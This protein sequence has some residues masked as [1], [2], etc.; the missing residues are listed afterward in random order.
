MSQ[1]PIE[2]VDFGKRRFGANL[3]PKFGKG[4]PEGFQKEVGVT[5]F[6]KERFSSAATVVG[7]ALV[8][9]S[10]ASQVIEEDREVGGE[11]CW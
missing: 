10:A 7:D 11:M 4:R 9:R 2:H 3:I 8:N 5:L 1:K 6:D